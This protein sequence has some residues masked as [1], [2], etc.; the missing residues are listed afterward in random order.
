MHRRDV[1]WTVLI[2]MFV[3]MTVRGFA[4]RGDDLYNEFETLSIVISKIRKHYVEEVDE[5]ELLE[6]A[7][8]GAL[9][10]LDRYSSYIAP[11]DLEDFRMQTTG[12]FQGL[13]IEIGLRSGWLTVI[14]PIEDTPAWRAGIRPG[15]RIVKIEGKTTEGMTI[16]Q[17]VK[18]LRGKKG[19]KVTIT[20]LHQGET[21]LVDM[22]ITRDVIPIYSVRGYKR[23]GDNGQWG[24]F[25][26]EDRKIGY[27]RL[28][29]FQEKTREELDHAVDELK[30]KG[31]QAL[32]LDLRF[33]PGGLLSSAV[34]VSDRFIEKGVIVSTRGRAVP[35]SSF[36]AH[37]FGTYEHF[38]LAVLVNNWSASASEIVAGAMQD[39]HRGVV[40]G[41]RT[42]GKG[43]VQN[44]IPLQGGKAALKLTTA[45][46]YTPAGRSI[47]RDEG[48]EEGGLIP[49]IIVETSPEQEV[50]L[51]RLWSKLSTPKKKEEKNEANAPDDVKP[52]L[53][54]PSPDGEIDKEEPEFVDT[55]LRRAIDALKVL[56]IMKEKPDLAK[57]GKED[58][59]A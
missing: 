42:F 29:A 33:N 17:A 30:K 15:D 1:I 21:K 58:A 46:Y 51:Q 22:T 44:V 19:T 50:K 25:V 32:V 10:S 59:A 4:E 53:P 14:S 57:P 12:E 43:S 28:R 47:H 5:K 41:E 54:K 16:M 7:V 13:G 55:Q 49:D 24:F 40:V 18:R 23:E 36:R 11:E 38:P 26:D 34:E 52:F 9:L 45:R 35:E 39:H 48:S 31:M 8:R 27:I 20:V 3:T 2:V 37:K 6:G 56:L